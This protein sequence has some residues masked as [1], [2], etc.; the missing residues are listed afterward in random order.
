KSLAFRRSL[1]VR[2]GGRGIDS[3]APSPRAETVPRG[4]RVGRGSAGLARRRHQF[5]SASRGVGLSADGRTHRLLIGGGSVYYDFK[6]LKR[7]LSP[8]WSLCPLWPI[9]LRLPY[10]LL[11]TP[12]RL[13]ATQGA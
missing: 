10:W 8:L 12:S 6:P 1:P 7:I 5:P 4:R 13:S 3:P 9:R 11:A 2:E